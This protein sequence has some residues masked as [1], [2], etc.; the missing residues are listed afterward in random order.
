MPFRHL[1]GVALLTLLLAACSGP[2]IDNPN[3]FRDEQGRNRQEI[4]TLDKASI[5][6]SDN[7]YLDITRIVVNDGGR[8]SATDSRGGVTAVDQ[9]RLALDNIPLVGKLFMPRLLRSDFVDS[10]RAGTVYA[11]GDTLQVVVDTLPPR[12]AWQR[13]VLVN[14]DFA[15]VFSAPTPLT[16]APSPPAAA[17]SVGT[18]YMRGD[19]ETLLLLLRPS[20]ITDSLF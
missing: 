1:S 14:R 12:G 2:Y 11:A 9:N 6:T 7:H 3:A 16:G 20:I 4:Y 8:L 5:H 15:W 17:Q 18:A 10:Q 13:I 19:G